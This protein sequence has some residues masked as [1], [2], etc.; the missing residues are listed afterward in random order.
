MPAQFRRSA[1][2]ADRILRGAD[3]ATLPFEQPMTFDMV[4]NLKTAR[5]L[6]LTVPQSLLMMATRVIE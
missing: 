2:F 6:N 4:I 1:V 5:M 3:P